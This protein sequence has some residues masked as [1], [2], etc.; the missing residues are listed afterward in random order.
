MSDSNT[1]SAMAC[2][3]CGNQ[4]G[5][6]ILFNLFN[7]I[8]ECAACGLVYAEFAGREANSEDYDHSYYTSGVYADYLGDRE[9]IRRNADRVLIELESLAPDR[10]LLDVGCAAGFFLEAA[11]ERGW[12]VHGVEVSEYAAKYAREQL[13]LPVD[14]CSISGTSELLPKFDV[15]TLWDT[16]EHLERPDLALRNVRR[17]LSGKG[18]LA[19][20][21]GDYGS[22]ARRLC[23]RKWRL[24][25]DPTH[26]FF[27]D[28]ET[29]KRLLS[30][31]GFEVTRL[32]RR[33]KWVSLS[34]ILHQT[35][36]PLAGGLQRWL[37]GKHL[38][39][40][41]Y[42]NLRDVMTVLAR[43]VR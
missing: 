43:P 13:H 12:S 38:N 10:R 29:L 4:T 25:S 1:Q 39:P 34:M 3:L 9:A 36:L 26:R 7:P 28:E 2:I 35:R 16:I 22:I 18:V 24:F 33:G 20:S 40:M 32:A 27:F 31:A 11:R 6:Q 8:V 41:L 17:L 30:E 15:I 5:N 19:I 42:V 21:T 37:A 14:L 23:G